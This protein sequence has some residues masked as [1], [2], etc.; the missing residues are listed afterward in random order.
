MDVQTR[1][2]LCKITPEIARCLTHPVASLE[3]NWKSTRE[4]KKGG[5]KSE[6]GSIRG[7]GHHWHGSGTVKSVIVQNAYL[8]LIRRGETEAAGWSSIIH[9]KDNCEFTWSGRSEAV[10][11]VLPMTSWRINPRWQIN[12]LTIY[13][14]LSSI[15]FESNPVLKQ[16]ESSALSSS[17]LESIEIPR[18]V[19]IRCSSCFSNYQSLSSISFKL[20]SGLKRIKAQAFNGTSVR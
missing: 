3:Q 11:K 18:S 8:I 5:K 6:S 2:I 19:E 16:I 12:P 13:W 1:A 7:K 17:S 9:M 4:G 20:I 15:S 10:Q 14:K